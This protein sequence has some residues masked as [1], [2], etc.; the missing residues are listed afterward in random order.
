M[1]ERAWLDNFAIEAADQGWSEWDLAEV[2]RER[3]FNEHC[4]RHA[5]RTYREQVAPGQDSDSM[6]LFSE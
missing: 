2:L 3:Q 5:L 1:I 6:E 4:V